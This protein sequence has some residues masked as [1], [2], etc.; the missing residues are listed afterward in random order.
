MKQQDGEQDPPDKDKC[1]CS[2]IACAEIWRQ[3]CGLWAGGT[4]PVNS[5]HSGVNSIL[6]LPRSKSYPSCCVL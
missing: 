5:T 4:S 1:V 6:L 2:T 3:G